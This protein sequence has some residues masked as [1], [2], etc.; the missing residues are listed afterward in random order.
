MNTTPDRFLTFAEVAEM[1]G[2]SEE[3]VRNGECGTDELLRIKLGKQTRTI[4]F[5]FN[6]VQVWIEKRGAKDET[7][8]N[9]DDQA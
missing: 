7:T 5:S 1:L 2:L 3:V 8:K 9:E 4:R 6:N